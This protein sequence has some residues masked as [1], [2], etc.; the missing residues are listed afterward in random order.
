MPKPSPVP[1]L[2]LLNKQYFRVRN[3]AQFLVAYSCMICIVKSAPIIVALSGLHVFQ[4][5]FL[6]E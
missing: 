2:N 4:L 5:F 1:N 3:V 6:Y